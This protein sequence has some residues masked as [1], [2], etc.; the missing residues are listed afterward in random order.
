MGIA[1]RRRWLV[2]AL[3][4]PALFLA[5][6]A[7]HGQRIGGPRIGGG[8]V[9]GGGIAPRPN[10]GMIGGP[11]PINGGGV[12]GGPNPINGGGVVGGPNINGGMPQPP[13]IPP[14]PV[15]ETVWTCSKCNAEL[16]RGGAQPN[17]ASCPRC[18]VRFING[19]PSRQ[20]VPVNN[21]PPGNPAP[22]NNTSSS[23]SSAGTTDASQVMFTI[24]I[25]CGVLI[26]LGGGAALIWYLINKQRSTKR[27][28]RRL[29]V[30]DGATDLYRKTPRGEAAA[31]RSARGRRVEPKDFFA[32]RDE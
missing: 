1:S 15:F 14:P 4:G 2:L 11:N 26:A 23:R 27:P 32:D 12:I 8:G 29:T 21:P 25:I 9:G 22:S 16:G 19:M 24:G 10:P 7:A 18:G 31:P 6:D 17:L 13:R 5:L 3:A 28:R 20:E 30:P